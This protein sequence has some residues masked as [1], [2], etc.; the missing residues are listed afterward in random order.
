MFRTFSE[1]EGFKKDYFL[2][3]KRPFMQSCLNSAVT[4]RGQIKKAASLSADQKIH[5]LALIDGYRN[6]AGEIP[7]L[8]VRIES[9]SREFDLHTETLEPVSAGLIRLA[10]KEVDEARNRNDR[11]GF[12][13]RFL[14]LF[15]SFG[16]L[17]LVSLIAWLIHKTITR[18]I[19]RLTRVAAKLQAGNLDV[20]AQLENEDELGRLAE[21]FNQMADRLRKLIVDLEYKVEIR[22]R[23]LLETNHSLEKEIEERKQSESARQ[24]LEIELRQSQKMEAVGTLAGGIAHDFNNI[25][26]I[27]LGNTELSMD[28]VPD[29]N[30]AHH[31][32]EEIRTACL[33][34]KEVVRQLLSFSRKTR[35]EQ[36]KLLLIPIVKESLKLLRSSIPNQ[37]DIQGNLPPHCRTILADPTQIHQ[38]ILN[39]CSNA[40]HAMSDKGGIL[41]IFVLDVRMAKEDTEAFGG[42]PPGPYVKLIVKDTGDGIPWEIRDKIFDPYFT[43]KAVDKGTGMG[44]AV[45]H[46]I[47]KNHNGAIR[48]DSRKGRGTTFEILFPVIWESASETVENK[49]QGKPPGG[50]ERILF[51][52]DEPALALMGQQMLTRLGYQVLSFTSP[53]SALESIRS[54]KE[55]FDLVITDMAMPE[56]TGDLLA[57]NIRS[58]RPDLPLILCTGFSEKI[59]PEKALE[60][61]FSSYIEKPIEQYKFAATVREVLDGGLVGK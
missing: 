17:L 38:I 27:V 16:S 11:I 60:I 47:V 49:K 42:L 13:F 41:E 14:L 20:R 24:Q 9:K 12:R 5:L 45:V 32:L 58:I 21:G 48:V 53:L 59:S 51:V 10:Q 56:M 2:T 18:N 35:Q 15:S 25:L 40:A 44:L 7:G 61:G 26:G 29:W 3:R 50:S 54:G 28:D 55:D 34:A 23:E 1:M 6:F 57:E 33:R 31:N 52:D 4:L 46:G 22:T 43:T 8:D 30:P 37:I 36:E 19:V 39:L